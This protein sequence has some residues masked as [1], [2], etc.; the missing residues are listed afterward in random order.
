ALNL[1]RAA[2]QS[3]AAASPAALTVARLRELVAERY[4]AAAPL[5]ERPALDALLDP[6]GLIWSDEAA[7]FVRRPEEPTAQPTIQRT[8]RPRSTIPVGVRPVPSERERNALR[9][10]EALKLAVEK[11]VFR[12]IQCLDPQYED[13]IAC[14][15]RFLGVPPISFEKELIERIDELVVSKKVD[16]RIVR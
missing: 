7:G 9:F 10:T 2:L 15:S 1:A 4:P 12:L 8:R 5:P 6:L 13:T 11:R 3:A 14:L 16:P